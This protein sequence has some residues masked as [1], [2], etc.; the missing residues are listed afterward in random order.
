MRKVCLSLCE[1][2]AADVQFMCLER[3]QMMLAFLY[4][5]ETE[6][7]EGAILLSL[8]SDCPALE[9]SFG[10]SCECVSP[11]GEAARRS[12]CERKKEKGRRKR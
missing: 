2:D 6:G 7:E 8:L 10:V 11:S 3:M 5:K 1:R 12:A 9:S 4:L